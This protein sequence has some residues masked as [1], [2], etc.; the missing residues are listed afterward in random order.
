M[1]TKE[2]LEKR[3]TELEAERQ[4]FVAKAQAQVYVYDGAIQNSKQLLLKFEEEKVDE[5][6][7]ST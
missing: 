7:T 6:Q 3:I 5:Q 2:D 1:I 4:E